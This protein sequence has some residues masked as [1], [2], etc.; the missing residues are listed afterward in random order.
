MDGYIPWMWGLNG[1]GSVLG[2]VFTIVIAISL[3]FAQA[4]LVGAIC[5]LFVFLIFVKYG[6]INIMRRQ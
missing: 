6:V 4:L 2:S 3:G 5:Y 1:V